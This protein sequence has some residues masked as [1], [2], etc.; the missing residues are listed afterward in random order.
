[1]TITDRLDK[2]GRA[3]TTAP[4]HTSSRPVTK[5]RPVTSNAIAASRQRAA[6]RMLPT[7][8]AVRGKLATA[9]RRLTTREALAAQKTTLG[10]VGP[11]IQADT[12]RRT[13][14]FGGADMEGPQIVARRCR[15][16]CPLATPLRQATRRLMATGRPMNTGQ[17]TARQRP[18]GMAGRLARRRPPCA[19][20]PAAW[21]RAACRC[22]TARIRGATGGQ[23]MAGGMVTGKAAGR[24]GTVVLTPEVSSVLPPDIGRK[25]VTAAPTPMRVA[26][27]SGRTTAT[28][29]HLDIRKEILGNSAGTGASGSPAIKRDTDLLAGD[30]T[31]PA[32][33]AGQRCRPTPGGRTRAARSRPDPGRGRA[34]TVRRDGVGPG[35]G[36]RTRRTDI[37]PLNP[38]RSHTTMKCAMATVATTSATRISTAA[39]VTVR[40]LTTRGQ[41]A[42]GRAWPSRTDREPSADDMMGRP[43][44]ALRPARPARSAEPA[45]RQP[46][47]QGHPPFALR[48][49]SSRANRP[50][51]R[52]RTRP[53]P[54]RPAPRNPTEVRGEMSR[55]GPRTPQGRSPAF[56]LRQARQA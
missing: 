18:R 48:R 44:R 35:R 46:C 55:L 5:V 47:R 12:V 43:V 50:V 26:R 53:R 52:A 16:E 32:S 7:G 29:P 45:L 42:T 22:Q 10:R 9:C 17:R 56:R 21:Q 34:A 37:V 24:S 36:H 2:A 31:D 8:R 20:S 27:V 38:L 39:T 1:M 49:P 54:T 19:A 3:A 41:A 40:C 30:R 13:A 15:M 25:L 11:V 28:T 14:G 51:R 23:P 4:R 6:V 33:Q